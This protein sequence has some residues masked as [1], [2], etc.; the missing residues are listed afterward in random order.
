ME[1]AVNEVQA[2]EY[3]QSSAQKTPK[4]KLFD[5]FDVSDVKVEDPGLKKYVNLNPL[6]LP[7]N[8]GRERDR[9]AKANINIVERVINML[10]VPGH[11]GKKHKVMTGHATGK[12]SKKASALIEALKIIEKKTGKNPVQV[13]VT[14][15]EK[16][17]PRDEITAIEYG[18]ARYPQAVDASPL[19]RLN[20]AIRNIVHG[21][22]EKSFGKKTVLE[23]ALA[24]ELIAASNSSNE[25]FALTKRIDTEK[26]ADSAR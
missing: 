5:L 15:I 12:W 16:S 19:R 11:R 21:A 24:D 14:A 4:M 3:S 13:L 22:Q 20:L 6:L 2:E 26:M 8:R 23:S 10:Q 9:F 1:E 18:G 17:A 25:S 7:K